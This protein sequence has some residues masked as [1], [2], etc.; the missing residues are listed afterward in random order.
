MFSLYIYTKSILSSAWSY[1]GFT[2]WYGYWHVVIGMHFRFVYILTYFRQ[3]LI[4]LY[5]KYD[6]IFS[7]TIYWFTN[8]SWRKWTRTNGL[9]YGNIFI[10]SWFS[11]GKGNSKKSIFRWVFSLSKILFLTVMVRA[12]STGLVRINGAI[13]FLNPDFVRQLTAA[14]LSEVLLNSRGRSV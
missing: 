5:L 2:I 8:I 10:A 9:Y 1:N 13:I 7:G 3:K 6:V 12:G 14:S 4:I 11:F